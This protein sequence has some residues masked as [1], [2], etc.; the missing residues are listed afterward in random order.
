MKIFKNIV[1]L[2]YSDFHMSH[3]QYRGKSKEKKI[4]KN[5]DTR[6]SRIILIYL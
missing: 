2:N 5:K 3:I 1:I 4:K 6:K